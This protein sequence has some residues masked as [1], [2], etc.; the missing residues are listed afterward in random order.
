VR[1]LFN[2]SV[3]VL[4]GG[5]VHLCVERPEKLSVKINGLAIDSAK[6]EGW[7]IDPA[8]KKLALPTGSLK[9]GANTV[10]VEMAFTEST[11]IEA[12]Y[13][14]GEFGVVLDG[15]AKQLTRLPEKLTPTDVAAQGLPFYSGGITYKVPLI[16][17]PRP[18]ERLILETPKFEGACVRVASPGHAARLIPWQPYR[19]DVTEDAADQ[20]LLDVEVV[21]TRRNT[22]GPLHQVPLRAGAYGPGNFTTE[23]PGWSQKYMLYPGGLLQAPLLLVGGE[24]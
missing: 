24:G 18:G 4:P 12:V 13:L 10:E 3:A 17:K 11:N 23:G 8:F 5:P 7:W 2:F 20:K 6:A 1:L 21:L 14:V 16:E 9:A 22:F 19:A 15:T